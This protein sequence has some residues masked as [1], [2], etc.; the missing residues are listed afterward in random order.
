[1]PN[2]ISGTK[3]DKKSYLARPLLKTG[4]RVCITDLS[5]QAESADPTNLHIPVVLFW[6]GSTHTSKVCLQPCQKPG[7]PGHSPAMTISSEGSWP[8]NSSPRASRAP[9][10]RLHACTASCISSWSSDCREDA[11]CRVPCQELW[12]LPPIPF[13]TPDPVHPTFDSGVT[14]PTRLCPP[15]D[16]TFQHED[17]ARRESICN[18]LPV[19]I[20]CP[21]PN[22]SPTSSE[23]KEAPFLSLQI[24][25]P[26][27]TLATP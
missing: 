25:D 23:P 5:P 4:S 27:A 17:L 20:I 13:R 8:T 10:S 9:K 18:Y 21:H 19:G 15:S 7:S 26:A 12:S 22:L 1:M 3:R 24:Q 16:Q 2:P 11:G 6:L 14:L